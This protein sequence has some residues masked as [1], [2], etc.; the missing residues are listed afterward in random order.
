ML[1]HTTC[2]SDV[3]DGHI[4][5]ALCDF[6]QP[7]VTLYN[8]TRGWRL[9]GVRAGGGVVFGAKVG[10]GAVEGLVAGRAGYYFFFFFWV[11]W[12]FFSLRSFG[13]W[14]AR[15]MVRGHLLVVE[16][17]VG[18]PYVVRGH[19]EHVHAAV[20]LRLPAQLVV[21]PGLKQ[22][23]VCLSIIIV[24]FRVDANE[25]VRINM[26]IDTCK[27]RETYYDRSESNS[28]CLCFLVYA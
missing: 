12:R 24:W 3:Y 5:R 7:G 25:N 9:R 15:K 10:G 26:R 18:P 14:R 22:R 27:G 4:H 23:F 28:R 21:V 11:L 1:C 19:V 2:H 17:Y 20:L 6:S 8:Y 16:D 13:C